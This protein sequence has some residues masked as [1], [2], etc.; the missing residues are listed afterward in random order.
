MSTLWF[1]LKRKR[2]FTL[3]ELLVVI[4]IIAIL[5]GLLVPAVQKVRE[6]AARIQCTNNLKQ[7]GIACHNYASTYNSKL[8]PA[9]CSCNGGPPS[10]S[11]SYG[12]YNGSFF[13]TILPYIEQDNIYKIAVPA[14]PQTDTWDPA[15]TPN[16]FVRMQTIKTLQCPA[17]PTLINGFPTNQQGQWA[18]TS[19]S[20]NMQMFGEQHVGN[21][22]VPQYTLANIPDGTS[23]TIFLTEQYATSNCSGGNANCGSLWAY[24]GRDWGWTWSALMADTADNGAAAL[25]VPQIKPQIGTQNHA[26][27]QGIHTGQCMVALGDGSCRGVSSGITQPTWQHALQPDDGT[28]LGADW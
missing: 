26:L 16:N 11:A 14:S 4:A 9:N 17:D 21:A 27:A 15:V 5:I 7:L 23:N 6:A 25:N 28:V 24:P 19:Y 8:P 2:A 13:V 10:P 3:I 12:N 18:G 1:S 22:W 20:V